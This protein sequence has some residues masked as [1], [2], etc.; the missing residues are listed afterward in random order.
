M[1]LRLCKETINSMSVIDGIIVNQ[2]EVG[3]IQIPDGYPDVD[4]ILDTYVSVFLKS[5]EAQIGAAVI[6]GIFQT[7]VIYTSHDNNIYKVD[8]PLPYTVT[9]SK[10][11]IQNDCEISAVI[12]S[13]NTDAVISGSRKI[14][15]KVN[16]SAEVRVYKKI[17]IDICSK[18]NEEYVYQL[19]DDVECTYLKQY[20]EKTFVASDDFAL[21]EEGMG[22]AEILG[23]EYKILSTDFSFAANR[24][25]VRG[26]GLA[27]ILL[28]YSD[29]VCP[30]KFVKKI[31]FSQI[32]DTDAA[33][34]IDNIA[35]KVMLNGCYCDINTY[36]GNETNLTIEMHAVAQCEI[37]SKKSIKVLRDTYSTKGKITTTQS[38]L[39]LITGIN[40]LSA[41]CKICEHFDNLYNINYIVKANVKVIDMTCDDSCVKFKCQLI[42]YGPDDNMILQ[43]FKHNFTAEIE[44]CCSNN[45]KINTQ[46]LNI[47]VFGNEIIFD[48]E[49]EIINENNDIFSISYIENVDFEFS[50]DWNYAP[51]AVIYCCKDDDTVW[52]LAKKY[53]SNVDIIKRLNNIDDSLDVTTGMNIIIPKM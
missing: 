44:T 48:G 20:S 27:E 10:N 19:V 28:L 24:L 50:D 1:E 51:S 7:S 16:Y 14:V 46:V 36:A 11:E 2:D 13:N 41:T 37:Y 26:Y 9:I 6:K 49:I 30:K 25:I 22:H 52:R 33:E 3:E 39:D 47:D 23:A 4:K 43:V 15:V 38:E 12:R 40:K 8:L 42:G 21:N 53:L 17:N 31:D 32:I 34:T 5:K 45:F 35:V 29:D 18:I